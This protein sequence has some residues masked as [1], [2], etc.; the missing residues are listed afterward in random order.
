[1]PLIVLEILIFFKIYLVFNVYTWRK[2]YLH[3]KKKSIIKICCVDMAKEPAILESGIIFYLLARRLLTS[4]FS[5]KYTLSPHP[6][7]WF[8]ST[9]QRMLA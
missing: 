3:E 4:G 1:M 6:Q 5:D 2:I 7:L 9:V 8:S